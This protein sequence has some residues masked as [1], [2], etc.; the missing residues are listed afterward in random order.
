MTKAMHTMSRMCDTL[1]FTHHVDGGYKNQKRCSTPQS[2]WSVVYFF[3]HE[4]VSLQQSP[5]LRCAKGR[6]HVPTVHTGHNIYAIDH[7]TG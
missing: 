2:G 5:R 4:I 6:E 1:V 7:V 3:Q